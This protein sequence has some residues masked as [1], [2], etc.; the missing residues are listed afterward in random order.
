M[1]VQSK[2]ERIDLL[3]FKTPQ[4]RAFHMSWFAFLLCFLAWFGMAPLMKYVKAEMH[5]TPAQ[6]GNLIVASV[7]ATFFARLFFGWLCDRIGP[8]LS[9]TLLLVFGSIPVMGI[10]LAHSYHTLLLFRLGI[11]VI[12]ASFVI[13]QY[14]TS[15]MFAP[16]V[17]GTANAMAGGWG[18]L[19]GG[20]TQRVMPWLYGGFLALGVSGAVSWRV[21]MFVAGIVCL[22]TGIAYFFLTQDTPEGNF[23]DLRAR[24][25][26]PAKKGGSFLA[27]GKDYRVWLL[28]VLYG[29]C[30]GIEL[31][32]DNIADLYFTEHFKMSASVA[33][34]AA[35]SFGGLN[36]FARALGGY[37]SDKT[38]TTGNL[39]SRVRWLFII[40]FLEGLSMM[41]F[42]RMTSTGPLVMALLV[43]GL[44]VCMGCGAT[45][46]VVPFINKNAVGSVS[47]IVGAGGNAA[48]FAAGFL[49]KKG[50]DVWPSQVLLLGAIVT[51]CSFLALMVKF[52]PVEM[53]ASESVTPADP[54]EG[55]LPAAV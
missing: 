13:T 39:N 35:L 1:S 53:P 36:L 44:F 41:L 3:D 12:G 7:S 2:A 40:I 32:I 46:A 23:R 45:Y 51:A 26:M 49:F 5:L 18:N 50:Y 9:Y 4:M 34:W 11:G 6:I 10:G 52:S 21:S 30:F 19:G 15:A 8:R 24:G 16:K 28:F 17:V 47:G 25:M 29:A 55:L 31:T 54:I 38:Q 22:L 20:I 43:F 37:F 48:A 42:S 14:H 27:A 33:G